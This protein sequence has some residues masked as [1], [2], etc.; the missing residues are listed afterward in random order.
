MFDLSGQVA[1]IT[2]SS[3]GIGRAIAH[4]L[5]QAGARVV[6][7]G[8]KLPACE[9]VVEEIRET[10]GE[11]VAVP[12][13]V[14]DKTQLEHL[15]SMAIDTWQRLD[16]VVCNAAVNPYFGPMTGMSDAVYDKIMNSNVRSNFW[17][18]NIA[19]PH[20]V[21]SGGTGCF[22]LISSIG[23]NQGSDTL[24]VYGMSKAA[25]Y[26]LTRNLAVEW[27]PRG[28]RANCIAPGL[29]KTDFSRALWEN[30]ELLA[31]V[32]E[33]TPVRRIGQPEDVGGVALFLASRA[34][35]YVTG[36]VLVVDGGITVK[37]PA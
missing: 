2:G 22:I 33:A 1:V 27:G 9:T 7:S 16:I 23:G 37:E 20:M 6:V 21:R 25:D 14:S 35:A 11:A 18:C 31:G 19:G 12:C 26:A 3:R 15:V 8:R 17:L 10:G 5:A 34:A 36:Q 28:L 13:N 30:P 24:G 29:I 4:A 32:E